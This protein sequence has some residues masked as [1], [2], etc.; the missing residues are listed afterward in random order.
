[1]MTYED[2]EW[3]LSY[4][5]KAENGIN[6]PI[7][8]FAHRNR[9]QGAHVW[10]HIGKIEINIGMNNP[11]EPDFRIE[12]CVEAYSILGGFPGLWNQFDDK[13]TIQQNI[14][15]HILN[16]DS[17]LFEE[18][19]RMVAEQLRETSVYNTILAAIASGKYK[20]NDI[21]LHRSRRLPNC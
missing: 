18:W 19:D 8:V 11:V 15:R 3:L 16:R 21:Y 6:K 4:A 7:I 1:M 17:Y 9:L 13:L 5:R 10:I 2:Y 20:L 14:C 12:E